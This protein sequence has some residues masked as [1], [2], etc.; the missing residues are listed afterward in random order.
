M[1]ARSPIER[2]VEAITVLAVGACASGGFLG[3]RAIAWRQGHLVNEMI[4]S[5]VTVSAV[6]IGSIGLV[7]VVLGRQLLRLLPVDWLSVRF[8]AVIGSAV[9]AVYHVVA[10]LTETEVALSATERAA[11]GA[12]DGLLIGALIGFVTMFVSGRRL[13]FDGFGL[14]RYGML[15]LVVLLIAGVVVLVD[16]WFWLPDAAIFVVAIPAIL[17]LRIAVATLDRRADAASR[18]NSH[19]VE[20]VYSEE[21]Q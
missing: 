12:L 10:P 6:V 2:L 18:S 21:P 19:S 15:Y 7:Y 1:R 13:S 11:Q 16:A 3:L 5:G 9:Y 8:G 20:E 4:L 17:V 14:T